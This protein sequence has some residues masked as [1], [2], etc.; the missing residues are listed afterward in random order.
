MDKEASIF[1][2][3]NH[4]LISYPVTKSFSFNTFDLAS[5]EEKYYRYKGIS[6][7]DFYYKTSLDLNLLYLLDKLN[8][9]QSIAS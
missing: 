9:L 7:K 5:L 2:E 4:V 8:Y 1:I 3:Y 6:K